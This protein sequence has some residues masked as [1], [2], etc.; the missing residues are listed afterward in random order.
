MPEDGN[1]SGLVSLFWGLWIYWFFSSWCEHLSSQSQSNDAPQ[2]GRT[3]SP[4][5][6]SALNGSMGCAE[7]EAVVSQILKRCGG[8]TVNDFL[9]GRLAVYETI[10]AAFDAGDRRTLRRYVSAEVY[11]AFSDAIAAREGRREKTETL[12]ALIAPPEI[13]AALCDEANAEISIRFIADSYRLSEISSGQRR[14]EE[15]HSIDIWTFSCA[16]PTNKWRL[17]ATEAGR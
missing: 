8:I 2:S 13:V 15:R 4:A 7:L 14:P 10:V 12:F 3:I 5:A 17:I 1:G 9:N 16:L 11:A 6:T